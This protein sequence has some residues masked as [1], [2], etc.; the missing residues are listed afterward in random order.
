MSARGSPGI[1]HAKKR[2]IISAPILCSPEGPEP[3]AEVGA[4]ARASGAADNRKNACSGG[5]L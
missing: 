4:N 2:G 1:E 3:A 5:P